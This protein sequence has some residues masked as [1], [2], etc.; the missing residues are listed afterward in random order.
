[1]AAD[2]I[3]L[4]VPVEPREGIRLAI[5]DLLDTAGLRTTYGSAVFADY[6]PAK[7]A[8]CV[9]LAEAGGYANVGKTNLHEFA[10]GVTSENQHFGTVPNPLAPGRIAGGSS[11]G[12]A[13]AL[14][15]GRADAAL[16]T[17]SGGSIRIPAACCG[18]VGFKPTYE[19]VSTG[20]CFPLAPSFDHVGPMARTVEECVALL[21]A[22][23]ADFTPTELGSLE[24]ISVATAWMDE[25]DPLVAHRVREAAGH[26]PRSRS[27]E[28]PKPE[29]AALFMRE[30]ADVH[31]E[32]YAENG[33]L[34][35]DEIAVKIE[36][37][38]AVS[39]AEANRAEQVRQEYRES[40]LRLL[41]GCDLLLTPTLQCVAPAMGVGDL[42]LRERLISNTLPFNALGWPALA[43]ACGPAEDGL[44]ASVQLV[45]RPGADALVLA[46]GSRLAS[47]IRGTAERGRLP[48]TT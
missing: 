40:C 22:I 24:E 5:K 8:A 17:D 30:V 13:A 10:Y 16:G 18:V 6:V 46:A 44:P 2:G 48:T 4:A 47:L 37:C 32:L 39:D 28:W 25:A 12:S 43:L 42:A 3:F 33:E 19:L 11:G 27:V 29:I 1:V 21:E 15:A 20:G 35:G 34:Y 23:A 9:R 7:S 26:F 14:A 45:G 31:R 38:L 41:D 36:R